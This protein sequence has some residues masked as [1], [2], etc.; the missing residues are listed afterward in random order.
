MVEKEDRPPGPALVRLLYPLLAALQ[1]LTIVPPIVRRPFTPRQLGRAVGFFPLVGV[2]L[3]ALLVGLK[4]LLV[5]AFPAP[6]VA[7]LLLA[8][9]VILTGAL[10]LDGFLDTCDGLFGGRTVEA[11]LDILR[12]ERVGAYAVSGGVLLMLLKYAALA[13]FAHRG[14]ALLLAPAL[15]RWGMALAV[16]AFPYARPQGLGRA[17]KDGA[18]GW[19]LALATATVL[20]VALAVG[21]WMGLL[22]LAL[23]GGGTWLIA[24][25]ALHRIPGLTGDVYGAICELVEAMILL[26]LAAGRWA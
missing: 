3:G 5:H 20:L 7:V 1:F 9:W 21:R 2:L 18:R 15:G 16:V 12:D 8:L 11:R 6:V 4:G 19:E 10:H 22:A 17:M 23:A 24:R 14:L 25:F 13:C 26:L